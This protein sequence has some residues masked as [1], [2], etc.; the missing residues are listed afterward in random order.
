MTRP[1]SRRVTVVGAGL[2]G[3]CTAWFLQQDGLEVTVLERAAVAAGASWG[4]AG[5]ITPALVAPLP[6]PVILRA[7]LAALTKRSSAIHIPFPPA[8]DVLAFL[9]R[10]AWHC[11]PR[12]W[13][14]GLAALAPLSAYALSAYDALADG[15]V[16]ARVLAGSPVLAAFASPAQRTPMVT[17]LAHVSRATGHAVAFDT[18]DGAAVQDAEPV[19]SDTLRAAVRIHGQRY[20]DPGSFVHAL[21]NSVRRR[22]GTIGEH[23]P[24][25]SL[26][27]D[28]R[29]VTI[30][31]DAD[32]TRAD[33][34]VLATGAWLPGLA[35]PAGVRVRV[36][37]GRGYSFRVPVRRL[38]AGPVYLPGQRLA[39]TP[40]PG[41]TL[42]VA[43]VMEFQAPQSPPDRGRLARM[44]G[45]LD[46]LLTGVDTAGRS[47]E[48]VGARPCTPDGLPV[49]G[50]T[51]SPRIFVAG[52]HGMWGVTLGPATGRLLARTIVTGQPP[53]ELAPFDPLRRG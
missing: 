17:E 51:R 9:A 45:E 6:D 1:A 40:M 32:R 44:A 38:P 42:R 5:W 3:L 35:R 22:G 33:A 41:G 4:N 26:R 46:Q 36:Q 10:F 2:V 21:A 34:V 11:T 18:L 50:P 43:G 13:A 27:D 37:S 7:G 14:A 19:L 39:C 53:P 24:V 29:G 52:G 20:L 48:W 23:A 25:T 8:P 16:Q 12:R 31:T 15:G 47:E 30:T 49:I 28:G